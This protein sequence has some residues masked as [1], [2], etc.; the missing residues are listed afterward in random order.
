MSFM[1]ALQSQSPINI[2]DSNASV[3]TGRLEALKISYP[4]LSSYVVT[5]KGQ[6]IGVSIVTQAELRAQSTFQTSAC[7]PFA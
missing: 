7:D 5:N 3:G 2:L 6:T 4:T 1:L